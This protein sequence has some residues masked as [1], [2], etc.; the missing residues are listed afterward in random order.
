MACIRTSSTCDGA[1]AGRRRGRVRCGTRRGRADGRCNGPAREDRRADAGERFLGPCAREGW[2]VAGHRTRLP[3]APVNA[4]ILVVMPPF[5]RPVAWL[6]VPLCALAMPTNLDDRGIGHGVFHVGLPEQ[7]SNIRLNTSA[8]RQSRDRRNAVLQ[9]P[10]GA[11]RS[12]H[13]LP[14]RAMHNIASTNSRLPLPL[15]PASVDLSR[16]CGSIS[17]H[18]ASVST[19]RSIRSSNHKQG[20]L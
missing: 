1:T 5:A 9:F 12:R 16:Q 20:H 10:N 2:S 17:A 14:V 19:E 8:A 4:R 6:S 7:V 18:R 15:R 3:S 13:G 11:G